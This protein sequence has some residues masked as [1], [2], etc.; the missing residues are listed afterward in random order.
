MPSPQKILLIDDDAT[1]A[2]LIGFMVGAFRRGP[3]LVEHASTYE[4]GL[5]KLLTGTYGLCLLD[6]HLG[7][8]DGLEL[9]R[10]A[11]TKQCHTPIIMLTGD[12]GEET[13]LAAMDGGAVDFMNK[14]ELNPRSLERAVWYALKMSAAVDELRDLAAVDE[15]TQLPNRREFDRRL[16]EEWERA[17]RFRRPLA[18]VSLDLDRFKPINDTYGHP[19]GDE[20]LRH[21]ARLLASQIRQSDCAARLGGDEF[22]LILVETDRKGAQYVASRICALAAA[23]PLQVAAKQLTLEVG[24][25]AGV[26]T[27]PEDATNHEALI[28]AADADL[29]RVKRS[30]KLAAAT[31]GRSVG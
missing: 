2:E 14:I 3:L 31:A 8:R 19:V 21:V 5:R 16:Q 25:S 20:V 29:Y 17:V 11:K 24:I 13:D 10:E 23:T 18:L 30:R 28:A 26:A 12:S 6:Y 22:A 15:L 27:W 4:E 9:L 1:M 7:P